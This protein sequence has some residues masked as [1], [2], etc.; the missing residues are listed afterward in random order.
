MI[1]STLKLII[2]FSQDQLDKIL[3]VQVNFEWMVN[4]I[5]ILI[6]DWIGS[7]FIKH[8]EITEY[9]LN[10]NNLKRLKKL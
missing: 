7:R 5:G 6:K 3:S 4:C 8:S 2:F 1:L 9:E 10:W